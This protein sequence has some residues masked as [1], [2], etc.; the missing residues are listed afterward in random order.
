MTA[1]PSRGSPFA[2]PAGHLERIG[3]LHPEVDLGVPRVAPEDRGVTHRQGRE[4]AEVRRERRTHGE[5]ARD[6]LGELGDLDA[7]VHDEGRV[8]RRR[9]D[10]HLAHV[11]AVERRGDELTLHEVVDLGLRDLVE[12]IAPRDRAIALEGEVDVEGRR[13]IVAN[14][15]V[16]VVG[17]AVDGSRRANDLVGCPRG[18]HDRGRVTHLDGR[19]AVGRELVVH[20]EPPDALVGRHAQDQRVVLLRLAHLAERLGGEPVL[21][22]RELALDAQEAKHVP[23]GRLSRARG[24][25]DHAPAVGLA[26]VLRLLD[27]LEHPPVD[28]ARALVGRRL[29]DPAHDLERLRPQ[30][31]IEGRL[32][33]RELDHVRQQ[34][35]RAIR[36][37]RPGRSAET[38]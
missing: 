21:H 29:R 36:P 38:R 31:R 20:R 16:T 1:S 8:E 3:E 15:G 14:V 27:V 30:P 6:R 32:V 25:G 13:P 5:P 26:G 35:R 22:E 19:V 24:A 11:S 7:K 23:E 34:W 28:E 4:L 17:H 18:E 12:G 2:T 37:S 33:G 9:V 10:L